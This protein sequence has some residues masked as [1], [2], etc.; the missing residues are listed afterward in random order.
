M[1]DLHEALAEAK[2]SGL[3]AAARARLGAERERLRERYRAEERRLEGELAEAWDRA[4]ETERPAVLKAC[5][6]ALARRAYL[7]TVI[8]DLSGALGANGGGEG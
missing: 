3:D 6:E 4:P 2:A 8:A 1:L 5:R 7:R